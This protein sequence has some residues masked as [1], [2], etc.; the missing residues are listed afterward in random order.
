VKDGDFHH[1]GGNVT[2]LNSIAGIYGGGVYMN[3]GKY[4]LAGAMRGFNW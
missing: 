3:R 2:M 4:H 1:L